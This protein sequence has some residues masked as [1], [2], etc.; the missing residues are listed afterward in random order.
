MARRLAASARW[1][2]APQ[3]L[4]R[5]NRWSCAAVA[6]AWPSIVRAADGFVYADVL[7]DPSSGMG[8]GLARL[9]PGRRLRP[10]GLL[11][12]RGDV[13]NL[14]LRCLRR[15]DADHL[16]RRCGGRLYRCYGPRPGGGWVGL[17]V[18]PRVGRPGVA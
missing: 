13:G 2:N 6:R 11:R 15:R 18:G 1:L 7:A 14:D 10:Y 4:P 17:D 5:D 8:R 12:V 3:L 9:L 16:Q